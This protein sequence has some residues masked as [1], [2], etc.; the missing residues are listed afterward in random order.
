MTVAASGT[1]VAAGFEDGTLRI[2][3]IDPYEG[4]ED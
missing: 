1:K 2:F 3:E 4:V